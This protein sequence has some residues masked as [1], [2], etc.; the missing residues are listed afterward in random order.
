M[1]E[2]Q[3]VPGAGGDSQVDVGQAGPVTEPLGEQRDRRPLRQRKEPLH[4][5]QALLRQ[6]PGRP[7]RVRRPRTSGDEQRDGQAWK[8]TANS[9]S[10]VERVG[11]RP[12]GV[13]EGEQHRTDHRLPELVQNGVEP[14]SRPLVGLISVS[15]AGAS[16]AGPSR[17][18]RA[19]PI[20]PNGKTASATSARPDAHRHAAGRQPQSVLQQGRLAQARLAQD[21]QGP[22]ADPS[23]RCPGAFGSPI[24]RPLALRRVPP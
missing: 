5:R 8:A 18:S 23:A 9:R 13:V 17:G 1:S 10:K 2:Q 11:V 20:S 4:R 3:R 7:G 19:W 14:V 21:E 22:A 16:V 12:V 24:A 15:G 6:F